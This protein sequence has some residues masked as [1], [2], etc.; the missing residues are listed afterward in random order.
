MVHKTFATKSSEFIK[1]ALSHDWKEAREKRIPLPETEVVTFEGYLHWL[2]TGQL[3]TDGEGSIL[4]KQQLQLYI[5]GDFLGDN[6][7][8][9]QVADDILR[10]FKHEQ[11][12]VGTSCMTFSNVQLAWKHTT[13]GSPLRDLFLGY[14][15]MQISFKA[16][17]WL[18]FIEEQRDWLPQGFDSELLKYM[19]TKLAN[20]DVAKTVQITMDPVRT[21]RC[22]YHKHEEGKSCTKP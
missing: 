15:C 8:C 22:N 1:A 18:S 6:N 14:V 3:I 5:L 10:L 11:V 17:K 9:N 16:G 13:Q 12:V 21:N 20:S 7:F 4:L 19:A 2:Y